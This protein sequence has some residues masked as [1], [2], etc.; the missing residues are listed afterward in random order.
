MIYETHCNLTGE[1]QKHKTKQLALAWMAAKKRGLESCY[2]RKNG[3]E[4]SY[5]AIKEM[6][7]ANSCTKRNHKKPEKI[8]QVKESATEKTYTERQVR[9]ILAPVV[10]RLVC[11]EVGC[12]MLE[13]GKILGG[14]DEKT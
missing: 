5:Q 10:D 8:K 2:L 1:T 4:Y 6:A 12:A 3:K 9:E 11:G 14:L 13:L 7:A